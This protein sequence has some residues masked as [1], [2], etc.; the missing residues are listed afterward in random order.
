MNSFISICNVVHGNTINQ[1]SLARQLCLSW[2]MRH[3]FNAICQAECPVNKVLKSSQT[4]SICLTRA[5]EHLSDIFSAEV[6]WLCWIS[7]LCALILIKLS[8][9]KKIS[10]FVGHKLKTTLPRCL[11]ED[12]KFD[13]LQ[14]NSRRAGNE[15]NTSHVCFHRT[16]LN[17]CHRCHPTVWQ[18]QAFTATCQMTLVAQKTN[19]YWEGPSRPERRPILC[20][21]CTVKCFSTNS[22]AYA[23]SKW[24]TC[25]LVGAVGNE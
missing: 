24:K 8:E 5:R 25:S 11:F 21:H 3:S 14:R 12:E 15:M 1:Y 19:N 18:S 10:H 17:R 4:Q 7:K 20:R 2:Q 16:E 6:S 13:L 23:N 22:I 9:R